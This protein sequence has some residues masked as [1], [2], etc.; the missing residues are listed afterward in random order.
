M[1]PINLKI[2]GRPCAVLGGGRVALRKVH[3]LLSA[4]AMPTVIAPTA[5]PE[6]AA[7]A[8]DGRLCWQQSCYVPGMLQGYFIVICA[9][10]D[11]A[12]NRAALQEARQAGV[13]VNSATDPEDSDFFVPAKIERGD[14]LL[15]ISTGGKSPAFTRVLR[16]QLETEFGDTYGCWL[17]RLA[18]LRG[19]M[20]Q[21]LAT[22]DDRQDFWRFA[23]DAHVME[24]VK[25]HK[26]KEAEEEIRNAI[27]RFGTQS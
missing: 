7:L 27:N 11:A 15:T 23:L 26:L 24:L 3:A 5:E 14:F 9:T 8:A 20:R 10:S 13:L 6:L 2:A 4:Q 22:S 12:V 17:E 1:Y 19:E 21:Q 25:Q 18:V 16:R